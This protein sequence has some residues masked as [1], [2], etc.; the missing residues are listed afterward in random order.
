MCQN[1]NTQ[2]KK[3]KIQWHFCFISLLLLYL[4]STCC[5]LILQTIW[6]F[7]TIWCSDREQI[8]M[9]DS[10]ALNVIEWVGIHD[11]MYLWQSGFI[12]VK[13]Q[14]AEFWVLC[15]QIVAFFSHFW[16]YVLVHLDNAEIVSFHPLNVTCRKERPN[17]VSVNNSELVTSSLSMP[18][19]FSIKLWM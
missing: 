16:S 15:L 13:W 19:K 1:T 2:K 9:I 10:C 8:I 12:Y 11:N 5:V 3:C 6:V 18:Y 4:I 17:Y 14:T 7:F